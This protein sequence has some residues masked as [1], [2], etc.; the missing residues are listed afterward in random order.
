[1]VH[2]LWKSICLVKSS[3]RYMA[4]QAGFGAMIDAHNMDFK[5]QKIERERKKERKTNWEKGGNRTQ[6]DLKKG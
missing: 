3:L 1:M 5:Y 4:V 6:R 2:V